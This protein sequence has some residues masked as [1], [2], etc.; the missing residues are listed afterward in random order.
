MFLLGHNGM[1][2]DNAKTFCEHKTNASFVVFDENR[3]LFL[4]PQ[5]W[6]EVA[7]EIITLGSFHNVQQQTTA[8]RKLQNL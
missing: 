4:Y 7:H 6:Q 1:W 8:E 2:K 3:L 5:I